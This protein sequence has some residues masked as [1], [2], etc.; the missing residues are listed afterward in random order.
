MLTDEDRKFLATPR[1]GILS[2]PGR[3]PADWPVNRP[4]WFETT[5]DGGVQLFSGADALKVRRYRADPRA[6]L[7]A[8][9]AVGEPEHWVSVTGRVTIEEDGAGDL[10][11]RLAARYW[12]MGNPD[13]KAV[14][15][16]WLV[17]D[18]VRIVITPDK[19]AR[20]EG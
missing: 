15:D 13:L 19:V 14:V 6:A 4:V 18:L 5:P 11:A 3:D 1:L 9:N 17:S 8:A 7:L 16:Q 2:I 12:D 10:A 20:Y